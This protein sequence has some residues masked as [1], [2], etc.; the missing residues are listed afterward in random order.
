MQKIISRILLVLLPG[1]VLIFSGCQS[2]KVQLV[3]DLGNGVQ[4]E[5]VKIPAGSF[6]MG[7]PDNE[8]GGYM[9][10]SPV[11]KVEISKPFLMGKFEV[12]QEQYIAVMGKNPSYF[13][14]LKNPV[15][16]VSWYDA[17]KFCKKLSEITKMQV[18]LPT[19]AQW[20]YA[21][22]GESQSRFSFGDSEND[23]GDYCWYK[24]NSGDKTHP[25]GQ[26]KPNKFGLYDMHGN[27]W[28]WC[29]DYY[30]DSYR[31]LA[32]KDPK[33]PSSSTRRLIRGGSWYDSASLCRVAN[34]DTSGPDLRSFS[35]GFRV[36]D[37]VVSGLD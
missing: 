25:V 23:L 21:A 34:R 15:E 31:N 17:Q 26:K 19:E 8:A 10:Q 5:F 35:G 11:R 2:P 36:C 14:G 12:T 6:M 32:S 27:V 29:Q 16:C 24:D 18:T 4:I 37:V 7:S 22:R 28:E 9:S 20:E 3:Y 30:Q 33:G 13:S 1:L